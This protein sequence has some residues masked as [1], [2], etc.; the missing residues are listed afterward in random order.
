MCIKEKMYAMAM[1]MLNSVTDLNVIEKYYAKFAKKYSKRYFVIYGKAL[2]KFIR[3]K[4]GKDHYIRVSEHLAKIKGIPD[5]E[6]D[7]DRLFRRIKSHN[8]G[9]RLL[10]KTLKGR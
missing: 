5:T 10:M 9:K 3:S 7:Y 8:A 1:D 2:E 6:Y 4:S